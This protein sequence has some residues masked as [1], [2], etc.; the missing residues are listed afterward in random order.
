MSQVW[1]RTV[2]RQFCSSCSRRER[3]CLPEVADL[4]VVQGD[5][6]MQARGRFP[7]ERGREHGAQNARLRAVVGQGDAQAFGRE[8]IPLGV[9]DPL[10]QAPQP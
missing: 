6:C 3:L 8:S 1:N 10:D 4:P 9:G 5:G 7:V 2:S